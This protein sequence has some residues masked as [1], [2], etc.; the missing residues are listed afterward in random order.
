[1]AELLLDIGNSRAKAVLHQ[2]GDLMLLPDHHA[3]T[4]QQFQI[5]AVFCAS[6]AGD[7]RIAEVRT[8]PAY[9]NQLGAQYRVKRQKLAFA[10]AM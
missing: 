8:K 6:V 10:T 2:N 4:L 1:V 5:S 3:T 9:N 7:E